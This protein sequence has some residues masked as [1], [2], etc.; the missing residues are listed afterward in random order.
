[1][2]PPTV[3]NDRLGPGTF[4][5][6]EPMLLYELCPTASQKVRA[7]WLPAKTIDTWLQSAF[8]LRTKIKLKKI[9]RSCSECPNSGASW[10][11]V[12]PRDRTTNS[13]WD[14]PMWRPQIRAV[15]KDPK[16][17]GLYHDQQQNT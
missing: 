5:R 12:Q 9:A 8:G 13:T 16:S 10:R 4:S 15:H 2:F 7:A 6:R 11:N 17:K 3:R 1:M 14:G